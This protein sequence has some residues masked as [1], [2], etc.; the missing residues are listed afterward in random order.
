MEREKRIYRKLQVGVGLIVFLACVILVGTLLMYSKNRNLCLVIACADLLFAAFS[1]LEYYRMKSMI[2]LELEE[3]AFEKSQILKTL[4]KSAPTPFVLTDMNGEIVWFSNSFQD[5]LKGKKDKKN[6]TQIFEPIR[7]KTF[8]QDEKEKHYHIAMDNKLYDVEC[9]QILFPAVNESNEESSMLSFYFYD[10]TDLVHYKNESE[11][12][13]L[14]VGLVYIDN[15]E[16]V[17]DNLEEVRQSML[18]A[19]VERKIFKYMRQYFAIVKKF[20]RDKYLFVFEAKYLPQVLE[21]RFSIMDDVRSTSLGN[22]L[23]V[24]LSIG[25]CANMPDYVQAYEGARACIDMALGRGGDQA[26]VKDNESVTYFGGN[27]QKME[28]ATRVKAR[29][30]AHAL[31]EIMMLS[32]KVLIM[33][34]RSPDA[35]SIGASLGIYR[36]AKTFQKEAYIVV[37]EDFPAIRPIIESVKQVSGDE[38]IFITGEQAVQMKDSECVVVV[39]DTNN[40]LMTECPSLLKGGCQVVVLDHHRTMKDT[41]KNAVLSY[42]EPYASSSCEMV[43]EVLQYIADKPK[44][45]NIEADALYS[46]IL[47]DTDNFVVKAGV[48]TFEAAAFLRRA[49]ADVTR[50]RKMFREDLNQNRMKAAIIQSAEMFQNAF[51][52]ATF[53]GENIPGATVIGAKAANELLDVQGVRGSFVLTRL[54]DCIYISARSIDD[55]NVHTIMERMGGGGHL[56]VAAAQIKNKTIYDVRTDLQNLIVSMQENKEI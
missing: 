50:V 49:G 36:M 34:H 22:T 55:L 41:I 31:R 47:V 35:D 3:G 7:K 9:R 16:E 13:N 46:G 26:V 23:E 54:Q 52:I 42:I 39:V 38:R 2:G 40:P 10:E 33:G 30:K 44:L 28:K 5:K 19:V 48:R 20:E 11:N 25:V 18:F 4:M 32:S 29:V 15:Y 14:V 51:A 17:L 27:T 24:T 56:T 1:V 6:I 45:K 8:P 12:K 43:A 37:D 53:E 21:D